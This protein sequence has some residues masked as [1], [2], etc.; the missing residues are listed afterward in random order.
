MGHIPSLMAREAEQHPVSLAA[1]DENWDNDSHFESDSQLDENEDAD[2]DYASSGSTDQQY[3]SDISWFSVGFPQPLVAH[4][5]LS[6]EEQESDVYLSSE[7]GEA[8]LSGDD[9]GDQL[10]MEPADAHPGWKGSQI[11]AT[12][13]WQNRLL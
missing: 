2:S 13:S 11:A 4:K 3:S 10:R 6:Q 5:F 8:V 7:D 12:N 9:A 1:E